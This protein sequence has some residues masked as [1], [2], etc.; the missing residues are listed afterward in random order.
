MAKRRKKR[1]HVCNGSMCFHGAFK[2]RG[3]ADR[4]A[5]RVGRR[6]FVFKKFGRWGRG[7]MHTRYV[8]ATRD[9]SGVPF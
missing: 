3:A 1:A 4:K 5:A 2:T 7:A 8:V 9:D 6:A